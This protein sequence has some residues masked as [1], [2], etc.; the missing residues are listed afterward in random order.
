MHAFLITFDYDA[1][2]CC[3]ISC[4]QN[5]IRERPSRHILRSNLAESVH[6][7]LVY[8]LNGRRFFCSGIVGLFGHAEIKKDNAR[9]E[10]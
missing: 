3:V 7:V 6:S 4:Y 8:C 9:F 10:S 5:V 2:A 1:A